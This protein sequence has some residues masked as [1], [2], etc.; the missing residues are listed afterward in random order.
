MKFVSKSSNLLVVL[1]PGIPGSHI[2]GSP[3]RP[4]VSA[5]FKDGVCEL[6]DSGL[7]EMMLAHP[8]F[9]SDF[10]STEDTMGTDPYAYLREGVEPEHVV[11]ELKYGQPVGSGKTPSIKLTPEIKKALQ[12][13]AMKMAKEFAAQMAP[14][15]AKEYL[16][17]ALAEREA[18]KAASGVTAEVVA[19]VETPKAPKAPRGKTNQK[20]QSE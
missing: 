14:I 4:Q 3:S 13:E 1:R 11:T 15:M 17:N 2:T 12:D 6:D 5:R 9:G 19:E 10:I 20:V 16:Q 18:Q 7:V 8:G